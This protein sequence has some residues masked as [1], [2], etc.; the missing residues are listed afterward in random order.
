MNRTYVHRGRVVDGVY[1]RC[2]RDC[3]KDACKVGH[4]WEY[5]IELPEIGG[6]RRRVYKGGFATGADASE[7]RDEVVNK[8]RKGTQPRDHKLTVAEWLTDWLQRQEDLLGLG[9]GTLIDYRRHVYSYWIPAIGKLKLGDLRPHH[10]TDTLTA[11]RRKRDED[12]SQALTFNEAARA[13]AATKD[14]ERIAKGLKRPIKP[15]LMRVPRPFGNGTAL[16]VLGTLRSALSAAVRAEEI[17]RNVAAQA[18]KPRYRRK[19]VRPW[20]PEQLGAW[21]DSVAG[22]RLYPL[23]HLGAFAGMRRG[24]LVGLTWDDIDLDKGVLVVRWQI[25]NVSYQKARRAIRRGER[26]VYRTKP[27]TR[28]G[29]ERPVD[30]DPDTVQVLR[31]WRKQ[32]LDEEANWGDAYADGVNL[33]FTR[34]NGEPWDPHAVYTQFV[35]SVKVLGYPPVALHLLRHIAASLLIAAGV[36]IAVI[37]KRLGHSKIDLT[38]DT[39]G[40]LIG[41]VGR[42]A[43]TKAAK[44]VP[45]GGGSV[46]KDV[47]DDAARANRD[48]G[49]KKKN[50]KNKGKDDA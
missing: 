32:Q 21:L 44:L 29:E 31:T 8:E 33:V 16:R 41:K 13:E 6:Q 46:P 14:K 26:P 38:A 34:E 47:S 30:L 36:D 9:E 11:I 50:R 18:E 4:K 15:K 39:Y 5:S 37:S 2:N 24:E 20:E 3:P 17:S 45:R 25:T 49:R 22:D 48:K 27:K 35:R 23:F 19:K 7:A 10:V 43:A 12:R 42:Q 1:Q 40:H 28:D